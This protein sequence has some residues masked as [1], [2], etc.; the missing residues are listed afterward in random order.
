MG[1]SVKL[2]ELQFKL[3]SSQ[4]IKNINPILVLS[5]EAAKREKEKMGGY[6]RACPGGY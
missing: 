4:D 3:F 2:G 1:T 6:A 5:Y